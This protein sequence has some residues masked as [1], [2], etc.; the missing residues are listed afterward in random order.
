MM[1]NSVADSDKNLSS[2]KEQLSSGQ[3]LSES[4]N[5]KSFINIV[6]LQ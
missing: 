4:E 2:S 5:G 3:N 6:F 1:A